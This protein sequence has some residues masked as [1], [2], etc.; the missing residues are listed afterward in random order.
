[1]VLRGIL[2]A[3]LTVYVYHTDVSKF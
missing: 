3:Y 1:M 2:D